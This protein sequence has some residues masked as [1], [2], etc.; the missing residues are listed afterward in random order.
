MGR[1]PRRARALSRKIF[2]ENSA[3]ERERAFA[4]SLSPPS[5]GYASSDSDDDD[6]DARGGA[7]L[8]AALRY[9]PDAAAAAEDSKEPGPEFG[10]ERGLDDSGS[11]RRRREA[12][13]SEERIALYESRPTPG[14]RAESHLQAR[15]RRRRARRPLARTRRSLLPRPLALALRA[16]SRRFSRRADAAA[17]QLALCSKKTDPP[18]ARERKVGPAGGFTEEDRPDVLWPVSPPPAADS[19]LERA[20]MGEEVTACAF[21]PDGRFLASVGNDGFVRVW[22]RVLK[23]KASSLNRDSARVPRDQ[24]GIDPVQACCRPYAHGGKQARRARARAPCARGVSPNAGAPGFSD[25]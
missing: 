18:N 20:H 5:G 1:A 17:A 6:D 11:E 23:D 7:L 19:P 16:R 15:S 10:A 4:P 2:S 12:V 9:E 13:R 14:G 3:R 21:S 22:R 25:S 8:A 24:D